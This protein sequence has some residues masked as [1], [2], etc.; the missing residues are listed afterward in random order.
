[1]CDPPAVLRS[2]LAAALL[3]SAALSCGGDD[4]GTAGPLRLPTGAALS[5]DGGWLFVANSDLDRRSGGSTLIAV[6]LEAVDAALQDPASPGASFSADQRCRRSAVQ[7]GVVECD[8][9]RFVDA[10]ATITLPVGAGNIVID[11]PFGADGISRL[12][13]P[14]SVDAT[15]TW[16]DAEITPKGGDAG[17]GE[18]T[19]ELRCGQ[20]RYGVCDEPHTLTHRFNDPDSTRL[21]KDGVRLSLAVEGYRYAYLPHLTGSVMTLVD[22]SGDGGPEISDIEGEFF[23][24]DPYTETEYAGGF[25]VAQRPCDPANAPALSL[26]CTRPA[27]VVSHRFWPGIRQFTIATAADVL[28]GN[29]NR[30]F[31]ESNPATAED[32][33]YMAD[34]AFEDESGERMLLVSTTPPALIRI[35]MRLDDEGEPSLTAIDTVGLC[36]NP[37][38]LALDRPPTGEALAYVSCY[39]DDQIAVVGL[40]SFRLVKTIDVGEGPNELVVDAERRRLYVVETLGHSVAMVDTDATSS[41]Y[42]EVIARLGVADRFF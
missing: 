10:D 36:R 14:S 9:E 30:G 1:M 26:E 4:S 38:I 22:L 32:L 41:R 11:R 28:L 21:P 16:I 2:S 19:L 6:D 39:S 23:N 20:D 40:G 15:I 33:P 35:D 8:V 5:P 37:N 24:T 27:L 3:I 12:L 17:A 13:I 7:T 42:L 34:L 25:A 31:Q 18:T 29:N